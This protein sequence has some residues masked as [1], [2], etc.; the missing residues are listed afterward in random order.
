MY[1]YVKKIT[2]VGNG[3]YIYYW[4]SKGLS[5]KRINS[6]KTPN[7]SITPNLD[8]YG[9]KTRV[10]FNGSCL[11]QDKV[12]FN[13]GKVVNIYIVYEISKSINI[14]D[15]PTLEDCLFGAVSLTKN[16]GFHKYGY[17]G[18]GVGFDRHGSFSFPG[19]GLGKN[20]IIFGVDMSSSTKIDNRKKDILILGKGPTQ[21]LEHTLS[22]EKMYSINFTVTGKKFCLSLHYNGAN[23]YLLLVVNKFINLKQKVLK[24]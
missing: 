13:H 1:R 11:K 24:L 20:V 7:H 18:Y 21:G 5:D 4:K 12:T 3:S 16:A 10:E 19:P 14:S 17:S 22:K 9:T 6:I 23:N 2:G 15:Y 8:Y